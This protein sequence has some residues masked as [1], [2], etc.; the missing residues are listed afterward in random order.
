MPSAYYEEPVEVE[1]IRVSL[2][3]MFRA[4]NDG[5]QLEAHNPHIEGPHASDL[6]TMIDWIA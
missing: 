3:E 2:T 4:R 5:Q 1:Y 6:H